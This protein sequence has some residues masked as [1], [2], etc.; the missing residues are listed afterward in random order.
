MSPN[1]KVLPQV[2]YGDPSNIID[3]LR[4][5]ERQMSGCNKCGRRIEGWGVVGC[6]KG[7]RPDEDG[8]CYQWRAKRDSK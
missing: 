7:V 8:H 4:R 5:A 3:T 1:D 6:S 2:A